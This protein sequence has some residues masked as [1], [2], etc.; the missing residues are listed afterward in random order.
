MALHEF[1]L[2]GRHCSPL[3]PLSIFLGYLLE[4]ESEG[5]VKVHMGLVIVYAWVVKWRGG[6]F[7]T[8]PQVGEVRSAIPLRVERVAGSVE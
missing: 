3:E 6:R 5:I 7:G 8:Y 4:M 1:D 2:G